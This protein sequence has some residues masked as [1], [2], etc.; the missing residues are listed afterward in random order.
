MKIILIS[1]CSVLLMSGFSVALAQGDSFE[2]LRVKATKMGNSSEGMSYEKRFSKAFT[3]PMRVALTDC[4]K[5]LQPPFSVNLVF[6]ID[7][8][9]N[10]ERIIPDPTQQISI[11]VAIKLKHLRVPAPPKPDWMVLVN[12]EISESTFNKDIKVEQLPEGKPTPPGP[13]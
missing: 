8:D 12:M 11:G 6:I 5:G 1:L 2:T 3:K 4:S 10:I 7:A 9:G 13:R